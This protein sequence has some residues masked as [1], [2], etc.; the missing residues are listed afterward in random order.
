[1]LQIQK[2]LGFVL[3]VERSISMKIEYATNANVLSRLPRLANNALS[4]LS[5]F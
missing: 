3:I 4:F 2:T 5:L 1:M